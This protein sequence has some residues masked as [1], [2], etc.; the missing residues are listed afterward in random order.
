MEQINIRQV[1]ADDLETCFVVETA[2]FSPAESAEKETI[3]LRIAKFPQGFL[4]AELG[5]QLVGM[6]N[7]GC[8]NKTDLCDEDLK[9][10]MGHDPDGGNLVVFSL[11]VHPKFQ[12]RGIARRLMLCFFETACRL[13]KQ[14]ILLICKQELIGYYRG[15]GFAHLGESKSTHGGSVWHEMAFSVDKYA[16]TQAH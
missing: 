6:L 10:L 9:K 7:S 8:T 12:K 1:T 11:A 5:G 14:K 4:V 3:A 13:K 2:C 16:E 15:L